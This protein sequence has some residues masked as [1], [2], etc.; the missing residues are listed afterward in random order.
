MRKAISFAP[1]IKKWEPE[2]TWLPVP[3]DNRQATIFSSWPV[4]VPGYHHQAL[5]D[6]WYTEYTSLS[7]MTTTDLFGDTDRGHPKM[8]PKPG[9]ERGNLAADLALALA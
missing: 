1:P 8:R 2:Q 4:P 5:L 6:C 9:I 3:D 7:S